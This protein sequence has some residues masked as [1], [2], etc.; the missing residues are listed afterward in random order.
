MSP[1]AAFSLGPCYKNPIGGLINRYHPPST[2]AS[3]LASSPSVN[4]QDL[5]IRSNGVSPGSRQGSLWHL[6][7][8]FTFRTSG[9]DPHQP[10]FLD[11]RPPPTAA[12][13]MSQ[14]DYQ[15]DEY[16]DYDHDENQHDDF[17]DDADDM[18]EDDDY[19][20][21][22]EQAIQDLL[23]RCGCK[24][25]GGTPCQDAFDDE[26]AMWNHLLLQHHTSKWIVKLYMRIQ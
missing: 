1:E 2:V 3:H 26:D 23:Y 20:E 12:T 11:P 22:D 6:F 9:L 7:G 15:R 4:L 21:K 24:W 10:L 8:I 13:T 17:E 25:K 19:V 16:F 14:D 5:W 18:N